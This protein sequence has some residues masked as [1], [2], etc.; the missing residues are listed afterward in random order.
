MPGIEQLKVLFLGSKQFG[1]RILSEVLLS[2]YKQQLHIGTIDDQVDSRSAFKEINSVAIRSGVG[3]SVVSS[4]NPLQKL[5]REISPDL[6]IVAGWY[7][8]ISADLL[9]I[10][11]LGWVGFHASMLPKYR[12]SAPLVWAMING[13]RTTG[14]SLFYFDQDVDTG[15]I[16]A[17]D[18]IEI[19]ATDSIH[20]VYERATDSAVRLLTGNISDIL[21]Q[22][23]HRVSQ[24][25]NLASYGAKRTPED[26]RIS[27]IQPA[28]SLYD[29]VRAQS[30][31]YPGAYTMEGG[32]KL[33]IW[34]ASI[35]G[36]EFYGN[37][38]Q[39]VQRS[40]NSFC[41]ACGK[42][43]ALVV[44]EFSRAGSEPNLEAPPLNSVLT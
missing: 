2:D 35:F 27:W 6:C 26:G 29:F 15:D 42:R 22:S 5:V 23:V 36:S 33:Y 32:F 38:G 13:E 1:Y 44:H 41:V 12:G 11:P 39:V 7:Q 10:V 3:V 25:G 34:K 30:H 19:A 37:P 40:K 18:E 43:S 21:E 4:K 14:V 8:I 16:I 17:Q 20:D 31:P 9:D 28:G 24:D